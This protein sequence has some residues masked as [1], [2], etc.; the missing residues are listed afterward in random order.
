MKKYLTA[1]RAI[2]LALDYDDTLPREEITK[3]VY[4]WYNNTDITDEYMLASLAMEFKDSLKILNMNTIINLA[5]KYY[6]EVVYGRG[7]SRE[8]S[9][10]E[11]ENAYDIFI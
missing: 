6:P 9:I 10:E 11:I 5:G 7:D 4:V 2:K 8:I 1:E 3:A